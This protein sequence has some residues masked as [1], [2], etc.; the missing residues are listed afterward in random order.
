[1]PGKWLDQEVVVVVRI[2]GLDIFYI[3]DTSTHRK[4]VAV[5]A[6]GKAA[7]YIADC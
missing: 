3:S 1:M 2:S 7:L 5:R 6:E 4:R